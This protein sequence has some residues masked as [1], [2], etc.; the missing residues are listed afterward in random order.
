[1]VSKGQAVEYRT[2]T[3]RVGNA[4]V[5]IH[6]PILTKEEES[7]RTQEVVRALQSF[8]KATMSN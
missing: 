8:A 4:V 3:I 5:N 1:M 7:K 2:S 6:R